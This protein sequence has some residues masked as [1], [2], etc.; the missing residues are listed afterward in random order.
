MK[1]F[2]LAVLVLIIV[3]SG[4]WYYVS[5]IHAD[6]HDDPGAISS[7]T[8]TFE[9]TN[10]RSLPFVISNVRTDQAY[11]PVEPYVRPGGEWTFFDCALKDDPAAKFTVGLSPDRQ[12]AKDAFIQFDNAVMI[13]PDRDAGTRLITDF[14]N[15][16]HLESPPR[17]HFNDIE[18]LSVSTAV[19][20]HNLDEHLTPGSSG[21]WTAENWFFGNFRENAQLYFNYNLN[22]LIGNFSEP[23]TQRQ[24]ELVL[25][26]LSDSLQDG[27]RLMRTSANDAN[28]TDQGPQIKDP[29][30]I[31]GSQTSTFRF[32]ESA[33]SMLLVPIN[34]QRNNEAYTLILGR[35]NSVKTVLRFD[36]P[37]DDLWGMNENAEHIVFSDH[38]NADRSAVH[39]WYADIATGHREEIKGPWGN[40]GQPFADHTV[41][42]DMRFIAIRYNR[43]TA[44][45]RDN[46]ATAFYDLTKNNFVVLEP[47]NSGDALLGW[48]GQGDDTRAVLCEAVD[49]GEGGAARCWTVSPIT[50][51]CAALPADRIPLKCLPHA[52]PDGS[53][54]F[55]LH[56]KDY[57]EIFDEGSPQPR[58]FTF[59]EDD[60]HFV[61]P[62][63][64]DWI[65]S[66]FIVLN[67]RQMMFIDTANMKMSYANLPVRGI[68][69]LRMSEDCKW[70]AMIPYDP[71]SPLTVARVTNDAAP[72]S[73]AA[74]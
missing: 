71:E 50:G 66:R 52:S 72:S 51:E 64:I 62:Q 34:A 23:D 58:R 29:Q 60:W 74:Q 14:G 38:A 7:Y 4:G 68:R 5:H 55:V 47:K 10:S 21:P 35:A 53:K 27:P 33:D 40:R 9:K 31:G 57:L 41:S 43:I 22:E 56:G 42:P 44:G 61:K 25:Y 69:L 48:I 17:M 13:V 67:A 6:V 26:F 73:G 49:A 20:G 37:V 8:I 18:P 1:K 24:D 19:F 30:G 3:V 59:N 16:F 39:I 28:L 32:I 11:S 63:N 45:L 36:R 54:R 65:N 70:A 15:W 2:G 12:S 46:Q